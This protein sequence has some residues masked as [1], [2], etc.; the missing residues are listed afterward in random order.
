M[1]VFA[2]QLMFVFNFFYSIFQ[3]KKSNNTKS[4]GCKYTG[5]DNTNS[6]RVTETGQEK[7]LKY[8]AGHM[9]MVKMEENLFRRQNR[10]VRMK[11][12]H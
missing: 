11:A 9:I 6:T 10:L 5:M 4:M 7:F 8:I 2:V 3:R 1:I 12:K